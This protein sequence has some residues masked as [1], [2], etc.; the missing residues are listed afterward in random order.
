MP[1]PPAR[2]PLPGTLRGGI[3]LTAL[4]AA[5][6]LAAPL[7]SPHD[8]EAQV[9][10]AVGKVRPPGTALPEIHL[11]DGRRLLAER[12][13]RTPEGLV[14]YRL[15]RAET[16]PA[17]EVANLTS[18]G[19]ADR[20]RFPLGSDRFG[21]DVL[22]RTLYGARVSL[23]VGLASVVLAITLG[24]A[25]GALAALGGRVAD[26][27]LMRLVDALLAFPS[28]F[29]VIAVSAFFRS[30]GPA[31]VLILAATSWM[32]TSRLA[33]AELLSLSHRDF[34]LAARATGEGPLAIFFR[35][36]LPNAMTPLIVQGALLAGSLI[37]AESALSFL[38]LGIQP[39]TPSWGNMVAD[40]RDVLVTAW[41]VSTFPGAALALTV[42]AVNLLADGLRDAL[43]PRARGRAAVRPLAE[44]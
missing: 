41:W 20:R 5:V 33:R 10:P 43:D 8:P 29:L 15:G 16:F 44:G 1:S 23:G 42:I 7:L 14:A 36:L 27:V 18:G 21:R 31:V 9:D 30:G 22:S 28:L 3:L 4:L 12:V 24:I 11:R 26:A 6:A 2:R 13:A 34:I 19:V 40:G 25:A 32:D 17:A 37:L 39:P 35:H 38:G